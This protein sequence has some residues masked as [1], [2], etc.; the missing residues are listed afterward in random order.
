MCQ[1]LRKA[2]YLRSLNIAHLAT[3]LQILSV[4][5]TKLRLRKA[6][7]DLPLLTSLATLRARI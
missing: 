7:A 4:W 1:A 6:T 2:P 5:M 3:L